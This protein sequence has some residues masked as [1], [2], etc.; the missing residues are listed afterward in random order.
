MP[1]I[2]DEAVAKNMWKNLKAQAIGIAKMRGPAPG[3]QEMT[4]EEEDTIYMRLAKG[5]TVEQELGLQVEGKSRE[6]IGNLK[7]PDRMKL[8]ASGERALSKLKQAQFL[9]KLAQRNDPT[10]TPYPR[11]KP[12][13][14]V[15][16]GG[17]SAEPMAEEG[18][19]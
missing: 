15:L 11:R 6:E 7:Y 4:P 10:W 12:P 17:M 2:T 5:W 13:E 9:A 18:V 3:K 16:D 8:A 14:P 1:D 19:Y